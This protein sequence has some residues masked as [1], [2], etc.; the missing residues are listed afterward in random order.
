MLGPGPRLIKK[1]NLP[2]RGLTKFEKHWSRLPPQIRP[3]PLSPPFSLVIHYSIFPAEATLAK[4][5]KEIYIFMFVQS[6]LRTAYGKLCRLHYSFDC[7][8]TCLWI[9][10]NMFL[11]CPQPSFV[12]KYLRFLKHTCPN[13]PWRFTVCH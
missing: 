12:N 11:V 13:V 10:A 5:N 7:T 6:L 4:I 3:G 2:G 1:K 8:C 9:P